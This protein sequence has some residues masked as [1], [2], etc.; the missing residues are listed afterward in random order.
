MRVLADP[1]QRVRQKVPSIHYGIARPHDIQKSTIRHAHIQ[2]YSTF[3][4]AI[5]LILENDCNGNVL[6]NIASSY[7]DDGAVYV[8]HH[9]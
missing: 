8:Q 1:Y 6:H 3:Q 7:S 5:D 4:R 2:Q 9:Q